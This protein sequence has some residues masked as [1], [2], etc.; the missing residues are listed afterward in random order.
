MTPL[1]DAVNHQGHSIMIET[2]LNCKTLHSSVDANRHS[3]DQPVLKQA[4]CMI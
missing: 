4:T 2:Y 1:C 3:L